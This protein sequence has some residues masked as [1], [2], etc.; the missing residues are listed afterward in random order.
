MPRTPTRPIAAN[1][2]PMTG[3]NRRPTAPV[4]RRWTRNKTTMIAAVIGTTRSDS[5]GATTLTPSTADSTEMAG[6]IMLSPKNSDGAEDPQHGQRGL[7][8]A[9]AGDCRACGS[10]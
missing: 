8:P 1:Q 2:T 4:P 5:D 6:V 9:A 10:R 3:P 7:G